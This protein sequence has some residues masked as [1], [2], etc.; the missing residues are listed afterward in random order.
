[1]AAEFS[2]EIEHNLNETVEKVQD[3]NGNKEQG[4]EDKTNIS[5][6]LENNFTLGAMA[7][8]L[9]GYSRLHAAASN[10]HADSLKSLLKD[11][12]NTSDINGKTV[13]GGY[14]PLHLVA[15]A[16]HNKCVAEM[17]VCDETD[18]HVT[19]AF[20]RTPLETAEQ[21]FKNDVA[22]LLRSHGKCPCCSIRPTVINTLLLVHCMGLFLSTASRYIMKC[23]LYRNFL[24]TYLLNF[25]L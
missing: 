8:G 14:T 20:G 2:D 9:F 19:D 13:G 12:A 1:M 22:K 5:E 25:V 18:I 11:S 3:E 15:S 7:R 21:N 23:T 4:T 24:I 10:G 6:N 17:L 16:G